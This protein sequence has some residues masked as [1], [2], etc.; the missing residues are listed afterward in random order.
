MEIE[1]YTLHIQ[2]KKG[3]EKTLIYRG[4]EN[5]IIRASSIGENNTIL[6]P[7]H[8]LEKFMEMIK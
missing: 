1:N 7:R 5:I 3:Y 6:I 4:N 2:D 8:L